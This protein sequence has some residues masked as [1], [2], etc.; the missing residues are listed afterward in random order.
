MNTALM[1]MSTAWI[2]GADPAGCSGCSAPVAVSAASCDSCSMASPG[3][4]ARLKSKMHTCTPCGTPLFSHGTPLFSRSTSMAACDP[5][6]SSSPGLLAKLKAR[7][8]HGKD[9]GTAAPCASPCAT[10]DCGGGHVAAS[11]GGC[12]L[13]PVPGAAAPVP[14]P[15]SPK[16]MPKPKDG[17]PLKV[18]PK[19]VGV[20][21]PSVVLPTSAPVVPF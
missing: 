6:G 20:E 17:T 9:C 12:A 19:K 14:S 3:L 10:G 21:V 18:E 4:F 11:T 1:L 2:A 7:F 13:P 8:H 16:E 15:E 5:C